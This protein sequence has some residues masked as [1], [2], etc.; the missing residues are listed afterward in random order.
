MAL[1]LR[2]KI[3]LSLCFLGL[4][5]FI[6]GIVAENKKPPFGI[7]IQENDIVICKFPNDPTIVLG[8]LSVVTLV[9]STIVG[10]VGIYFPYKGK[11][12]SSD[13]LFKSTTLFS[14]FIIAEILSIFTMA[15]LVWTIITEGLHRSRNVHHDITTQCPT[16]KTGM[17]GGS[18]FLALDATLFWLVCQMLTMNVRSDYLDEDKNEGEYGQISQDEA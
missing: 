13:I 10:H 1:E 5:S 3:A 6:L 7:P 9:L 18:A 15:L 12:I 11:S 14:F 4:L 8:S 2:T 17:F 16:A